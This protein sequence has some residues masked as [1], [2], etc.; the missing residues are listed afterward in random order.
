M[1]RR[2]AVD[3]YRSSKGWDFS[4]DSTPKRVNWGIKKDNRG[5]E[6]PSWAEPPAHSYRDGSR[7]DGKGQQ[8]EWLPPSLLLYFLKLADQVQYIENAS[9]HSAHQTWIKQSLLRRQ[10]GQCDN[11]W[12]VKTA[13]KSKNRICLQRISE[14]QVADFRNGTIAVAL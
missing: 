8:D 12:E 10:K 14:V 7:C 5:I 11:R 3:G 1:K 9:E 6:K 4:P 2:I 13:P